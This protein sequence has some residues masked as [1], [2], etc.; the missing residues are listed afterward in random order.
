MARGKI[1][2]EVE[3]SKKNPSLQKVSK[4]N[5]NIKFFNNKFVMYSHNPDLS[6]SF[7]FDDLGNT[8]ELNKILGKGAFGVV[9]QG[10]ILKTGANVAIKIQNITQ[11][12]EYYF[13][14]IGNL[15][16]ARTYVIHQIEREDSILQLTGQ[17]I[18]SVRRTNLKNQEKHYSIMRYIEGGKLKNIFSDFS[19]SK[20]LQAFIELTQQVQFLHDNDYLHLDIWPDNILWDG[21]AVLHDYGCGA[22]LLNGTFVSQLKGSHIPPEIIESHKK[23]TPCIY[24]KSSDTYAL[25]MTFYELFYEDYFDYTLH[26]T[27]DTFIK[28]YTVYYRKALKCLNSKGDLISGLIIQMIN[29]DIKQRLLTT[30]ILSSLVQIKEKPNSELNISGTSLSL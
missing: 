6:S 26:N 29:P 4:Y 10:M 22:K 5:G 21:R 17:Y 9:K 19:I 1:E 2:Q 12:I 7:L 23:H 16:Q 25:G 15:E 13:K 14:S 20:K 3:L 30:E 8:Y 27:I 28:P 18:A 24:R 11:Q